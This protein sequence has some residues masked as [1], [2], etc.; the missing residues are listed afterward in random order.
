MDLLELAPAAAVA[1]GERI[2]VQA[3]GRRATATFRDAAVRNGVRAGKSPTAGPTRRPAGHAGAPCGGADVPAA[4]LA[5]IAGLRRFRAP[6][7][8][9]VPRTAAERRAAGLGRVRRFPDAQPVR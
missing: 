6:R 4:G 9:A 1:G 5:A 7:Q 8:G 2:P 3:R